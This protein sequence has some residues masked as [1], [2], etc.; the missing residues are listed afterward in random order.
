M[1]I[2]SITSLRVVINKTTIVVTAFSLLPF[3]SLVSCCKIPQTIYL[4][5]TW[6]SMK[7]TARFIGG[8]FYIPSIARELIPDFS[9][10]EKER[11]RER[12]REKEREREREISVP[13]NLM[14]GE[15]KFYTGNRHR[16]PREHAR[17]TR[18][19]CEFHLWIRPLGVR[20]R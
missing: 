10:R 14:V 19:A 16:Y 15:R 9:Q 3:F 11:E 7:Q 17:G 20:K 5:I 12:E 18:N 8:G 2:T 6:A 13:R 1:G 4:E